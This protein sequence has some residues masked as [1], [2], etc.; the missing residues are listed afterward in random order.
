M[1]V[2]SPALIKIT[3]LTDFRGKWSEAANDLDGHLEI[4]TT[5]DVRE[6]HAQ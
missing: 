3:E 5:D 6:G 4:A 2:V 1:D